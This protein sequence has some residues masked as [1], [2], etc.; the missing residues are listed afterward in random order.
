MNE[1]DDGDTSNHTIKQQDWHSYPPVVVA[2]GGDM[3][4]TGQVN[5]DKTATGLA[6]PPTRA[7]SYAT[8]NESDD[9]DVE[10][11]SSQRGPA[12]SIRSSHDGQRHTAM[13]ADN[14]NLPHMD[15]EAAQAEDRHSHD[16]A[17]ED[18]NEGTSPTATTSASSSNTMTPAAQLRL[19]LARRLWSGV[20]QLR[21]RSRCALLFQGAFTVAQIAAFVIMLA[22]SAKQTCVK[23]LRVF[24]ALH[25]VRIAV[26]YPVSFYNALAP[27]RYVLLSQDGS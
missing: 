15:D 8:A 1:V 21:S 3:N 17:E 11:P 6:R 26:A 16:D 12:L 10:S 20:T 7:S 4:S 13:S 5:T 19:S 18:Y 27:P 2:L 23:P 25:V 22:L 14:G 24:I 9:N